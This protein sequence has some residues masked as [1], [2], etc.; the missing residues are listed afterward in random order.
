MYVK[1]L[2]TAFNKIAA[3]I[4][5]VAGWLLVGENNDVTI[6]IFFWAL[7]SWFIL[8]SE[9]YFIFEL[10]IIVTRDNKVKLRVVKKVRDS[11]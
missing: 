1:V 7:A 2:E 6:T 9:N 10:H 8:A 11:K 3:I 4:L 5:L